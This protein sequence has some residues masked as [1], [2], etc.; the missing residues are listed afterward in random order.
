MTRAILHV[1]MDAFFASIEQLDHPEW[2]GR[3]V[4]VGA[5][6]NQRGV[7]STCSYEARKFGVHSAMPSR[8]AF[9]CCPQGIFVT[10][11]ITRYHEIS[12]AVFKIFSDFSPFIEGISVDEAFLDVSS[13]Q[14][15]LGTPVQ[16][17]EK[18]KTR[19]RQEL[20]LTCSV[21]IASNKFLAKLASE[22]KKPDGLFEVPKERQHLL[23]WLGAK[24]VQTLW[25]IGPKT[26]AI[27]KQHGLIRVADLQ[28]AAPE[29]LQAI[30]SPTLAAHLLEIAF[31]RD[32]RPVLAEHEEKSFSREHTYPEDTLDRLQLKADLRT[33]VE[34]VGFRLRKAGLWAKTGKLKIRYAGFRTVTRQASLPTP[35]CDDF[36]LRD[37]AW[38]LLNTHLETETPVRLIGFGVDQ[39]TS[40]PN[41][42][43]SDDLFSKC[44][45]NSHTRERMERLSRALDA[46]RERFGKK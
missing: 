27:L 34:N 10:P 19:I 42:L 35:V 25:G 21:G 33:L 14:R 24:P 7:V 39:L 23:N 44:T 30:T 31:G 11:R 37:L 6:P 41:L 38:D 13:V 20:G 28:H 22:E 9:A 8:Q 29:C 36:A 16:I 26:T 43:D 2:R 1:D 12:Q 32:D 5:P 18:I 40:T 4:I 46:L 17:A 45:D 3:P 15:L